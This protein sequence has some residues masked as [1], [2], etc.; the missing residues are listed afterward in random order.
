MLFLLLVSTV[1]VPF[2]FIKYLYYIFKYRSAGKAWDYLDDYENK[3]IIL[4]KKKKYKHIS[5]L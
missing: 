2:V 5:K 4:F 1:G 3:T